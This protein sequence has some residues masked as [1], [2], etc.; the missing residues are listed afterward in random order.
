VGYTQFM[1]ESCRECPATLFPIILILCNL[2]AVL[3]VILVIF[4][5]ERKFINDRKMPKEEK[6]IPTDQNGDAHRSKHH[7]E[8]LPN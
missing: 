7:K 2:F 1:G 8:K 6:V 3:A 5:G 4:W